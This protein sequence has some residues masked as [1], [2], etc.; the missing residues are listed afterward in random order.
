M[1]EYCKE[2]LEKVEIRICIYET[3]KKSKFVETC[4]KYEDLLKHSMDGVVVK[5]AE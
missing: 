1:K 4:C 2:S 5:N 3:S